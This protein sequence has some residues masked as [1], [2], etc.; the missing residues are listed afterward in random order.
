MATRRRKLAIALVIVVIALYLV[1]RPFV[2]G[3]SS[4]RTF[5]ESLPTG[6]GLQDID[7]RAKAQGYRLMPSRDGQQPMLI[8]DGT[9]MG[10]FICQV[11]TEN[12]Q[13]VSTRY[14]LND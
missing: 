13:L 2:G 9:A 14:I 4:M 7:S 1:A 3:S 5:C 8:V 6:I 11:R 10:R 12:D